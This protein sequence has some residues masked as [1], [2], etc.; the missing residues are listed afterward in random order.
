MNFQ[1]IEYF[2][3]VVEYGNFTKAAQSLYISQQSLSENIHRL[4][5]EIG[6]PLLNRGRTL[7]LTPAGECFV[8]GGR[9]ILSTQDKMLREIAAVSNTSRSKIVIGVEPYDLPPFLP[10][11][12]SRFA[13]DYPE[14]DV[15]INP[16]RSPDTADL[17]FCSGEPEK[18]M[19]VIPLITDDPYVLVVSP[20]FAAQTF[21]DDWASVEKTLK[22]NPSLSGLEKLPFLLL[23]QNKHLL[24]PLE[25]L[26]RKAGFTPVEAFQSEDANLLCSLCS[27]GDGAFI[28]PLNYCRRKFG[29]QL[30]EPG[31]SRGKTAPGTG[32]LYCYPVKE[33]A[34]G[35]LSLT[36]PK[37]KHL[38]QAEKRFADTVKKVLES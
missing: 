30:A 28:G 11:V 29:A 20:S 33:I 17:T 8:S 34:P 23:Y 25:E 2:L 16:P 18:S 10:D 15:T 36:Y 5:E 4:E 7:T 37:G 19:E 3:A 26:F 32:S 1:N 12:L 27:A 13:R 22:K 31:V 21:G 35:S 24:P 14:Y 9:K 6:T 38:N